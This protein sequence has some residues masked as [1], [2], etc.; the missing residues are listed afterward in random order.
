MTPRSAARLLLTV[1]LLPSDATAQADG[2]ILGATLTVQ[3]ATDSPTRVE[4]EYDLSRPL[5]SGRVSWRALAFAGALPTDVTASVGGE[6]VA[7]SLDASDLPLL[8]GSV[9]LGPGSA[10][11]GADSESGGADPEYGAALGSSFSLVFTYR[12]PPR[13]DAGEN[14]LELDVPVLLLDWPPEAAPEGMFKARLAFPPGFAPVE[15]F[16]TVPLLERRGAGGEVSEY[17]LS[18]PVI[19]SLVRVRAR[20]GGPRFLAFGASVDAVVI[21]AL[22]VVGWIGWRRFRPSA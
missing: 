8:R 16:P 20:L 7:V 4:L 1:A 15:R 6:P 9:A 14:E 10:V 19:P 22:L 2:R 11:N 3:A 17:E 5:E 18:L 21:G 12:L 13:G